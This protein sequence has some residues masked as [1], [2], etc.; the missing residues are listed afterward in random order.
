MSNE[1][2]NNQTQELA[3]NATPEDIENIIGLPLPQASTDEAG[4]GSHGREALF[5]RK[6]SAEEKA[7]AVAK[8]DRL[9]AEQL[10]PVT[11][12]REFK[13]LKQMFGRASKKKA[14][15]G[16]QEDA[17]HDTECNSGAE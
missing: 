6:L 2:T 7:A 1:N 8:L 12:D 14:A 13:L 9:A 3:D 15:K 4:S 5:S 17:P 10:P 16:R 11:D